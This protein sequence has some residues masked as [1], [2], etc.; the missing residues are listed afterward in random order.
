MPG[1]IELVLM[2]VIAAVLILMVAVLLQAYKNSRRLEAVISH[3]GS[4]MV[5]QLMDENRKMR[6]ELDAR[7]DRLRDS[8]ANMFDTNRAH[9]QKA[10][11][12]MSKDIQVALHNF[13]RHTSDGMEKIRG[14]V[15]EKMT[16]M[17]LSNVQKLDEMQKVVDEK[18][19]K[20]LETRLQKSFETVS[21]QLESVN[22]G[23]GEM[24]TVAQSVGSLSRIL[25]GTKSRGI[26]GEV[27]LGQIIEDMLPSQLYDREVP[28]ISGSTSRVEYAVKLPGMGDGEHVYLPIDSKFPLETYERLLDCYEAG[29]SAEVDAARRAL[30]SRIKAFAKDIRDKYVSPPETTNFAVMFL[31]TEGL[32]AEIARD[33]SFFDG[34]RQDGIIICGPTTISAMLNSLQLGFKT[35]QIQK[36]A[37]D[38]EKT[39][40]AVKKEFGNFEGVLAKAHQRIAQVGSD[41]ENLVGTRTRA[42]NRSLRE[43]QMYTGEDSKQVLGMID[44]GVEG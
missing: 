1:Y 22:R 40:G 13:L 37:A 21:T 41:I 43:V 26:L 42:I 39:L 17:Q 30:Y 6:E 31:P 7:I 28:T 32:Y 24:K 34:L 10:M 33:A 38:I 12:D 23:L 20:T 5:A 25:S 29:D 35:L 8:Q 9:N 11:T 16:A 14:S 19:E 44:D 27:Q 4:D 2:L 18:L 3:I 36:G 15:D